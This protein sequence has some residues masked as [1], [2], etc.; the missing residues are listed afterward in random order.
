M[1]VATTGASTPARYR[2]NL[3]ALQDAQKPARG[4]PAYSRLVNRPTARRVAAAAHVVGVTPNAV[5]ALSAVLSAAGLVLLAVGRPSWP[6]GLAVA[7]LLATGFVLDSVDGQLARLRNGG[8]ATGEWLD[9]NVDCVKT[10]ALHLAVLVSWY[11]FPPVESDAALLLP[12]GFQVID[13]VVFFGFVMMPLIRRA[14]AHGARPAPSGPAPRPEHPLRQWLILPTD[15]GTFCWMFVLLGW[16]LGLFAG[17][18]ALFAVNAAVLPLILRKWWR[19]LRALDH[20][21]A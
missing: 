9:H 1:L 14:H 10:T 17:Y 21:V 6:L 12:L 2:D 16:P 3:R 20:A 11:R 19:E 15:Y 7:T 5:T 4:T 8:T 18:A 13:L